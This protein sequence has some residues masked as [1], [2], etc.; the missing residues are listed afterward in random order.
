M[1]AKTRSTPPWSAGRSLVE[2]G[3]PAVLGC[4][5]AGDGDKLVVGGA[6][7]LEALSRI[8]VEGDSG[9]RRPR[10]LALRRK[11]IRP[12]RRRSNPVP[13]ARF[14]A[15]VGLGIRADSWWMKSIPCRRASEGSRASSGCPSTRS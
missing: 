4:E 3:E 14:S 8:D 9:E 15:T 7:I 5:H 1:I 6:E 13:S 10:G 11:S 12:N 2:D